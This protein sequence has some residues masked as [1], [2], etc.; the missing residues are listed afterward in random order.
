MQP[1]T[2]NNIILIRK[3]K[4]YNDCSPDKHAKLHAKCPEK[5]NICNTLA[6]RLSES[7][8]HGTYLI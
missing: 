1:R 7:R 6:D 2:F 5:R 8:V 4:Y 3:R